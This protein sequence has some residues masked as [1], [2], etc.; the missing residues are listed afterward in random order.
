MIEG[1]GEETRPT[2]FETEGG[3]SCP[4]PYSPDIVLRIAALYSTGMSLYQ[5]SR[6]AEMPRYQ[7]L[8][9]WVKKHDELREALDAVR[10]LRA[11][12]FEDKALTVAEEA[13]GK[14]ADRIRL[15]AF[16]WAAEV[17]DPSRYGKRTV[18]HEGSGGG[19]TIIVNTGFGEPNDW[20]KPPRL[21]ADG[22]I[23]RAI[24]VKA[25]VADVEAKDPE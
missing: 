14:D 18:T 12:H 17:N 6:Q 21:G 13:C 11:L 4:V 5:I 7:S 2:V 19:T 16:K 3:S 8:L 9:G 25:E 22:L 15:D 20:Q 1:G 23:E 24:A 10:A